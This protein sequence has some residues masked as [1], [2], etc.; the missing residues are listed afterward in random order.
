MRDDRGLDFKRCNYLLALV[1]IDQNYLN[2]NEEQKEQRY[3]LCSFCSNLLFLYSRCFL[4][5]TLVF[6]FEDQVFIGIQRY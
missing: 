2:L 6:A 3:R 1:I 4:R 5:F